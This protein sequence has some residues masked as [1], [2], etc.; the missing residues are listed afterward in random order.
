MAGFFGLALVV[1]LPAGAV[2]L[3][4]SLSSSWSEIKDKG[5]AAV[6]SATSLNFR[7]AANGLA[8]TDR[9]LNRVNVL[10]VAVSQALPQT[11]DAYATARS[12]VTAG[13]QATPA[14]PLP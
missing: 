12:L 9:A 11:R 13:E 2:S 6:E 10:A 8:E 14:P 3:S 5:I 4:R 1:S 7:E